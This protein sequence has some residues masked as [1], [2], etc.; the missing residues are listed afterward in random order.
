MPFQRREAVTAFM[1]IP[2]LVVAIAM[3]Q[4]T[5][6]SIRLFIF[7]DVAD[8]SGFIKVE[9]KG[10]LDSVNDLKPLLVGRKGRVN[11]G[12]VTSKA[13]ADVLVQVT[14][15]EQDEKDRDNRVVHVRVTVGDYV[16]TIDGKD[17][18]GSWR[19]AAKDAA[20]QLTK[21]LELNQSRINAEKRAA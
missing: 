11:L 13:E 4:A 5:P 2:L 20:K 19:D 15:R 1:L 10:V 7:A 12:Q 8:P 6:H 9:S 17:D 16:F 21:W 3:G 14:G 18:D